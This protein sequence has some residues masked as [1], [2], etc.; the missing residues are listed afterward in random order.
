[1]FFGNETLEETIRLFRGTKVLVAAHGGGEANMLFMP[2]GGIVIE[3]RPQWWPITCFID[4]ADNIGAQHH[5]LIAQPGVGN[6]KQASYERP[7][8]DRLNEMV[9]N[10]TT[11]MPWIIDIIDKGYGYKT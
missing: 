4:L 2:P 10:M 5:M 6:G 7:T 9:V 1:M 8:P 3:V 11:F